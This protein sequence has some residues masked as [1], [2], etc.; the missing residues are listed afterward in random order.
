MFLRASPQL[1]SYFSCIQVPDEPS[2]FN[3][4]KIT[5]VRAVRD[6]IIYRM[7]VFRYCQ[8]GAKMLLFLQLLA[9]LAARYSSAQLSLIHRVWE[10]PFSMSKSTYIVELRRERRQ[11]ISLKL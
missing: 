11:A 10:Q 6:E 7:D 5:S 2:E 8:I 1:A 3:A 4:H 9:L